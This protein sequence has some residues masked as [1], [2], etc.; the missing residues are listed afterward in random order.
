MKIVV[1]FSLAGLACN[2]FYLLYKQVLAGA[3]QNQKQ[4]VMHLFVMSLVQTIMFMAGYYFARSLAPMIPM[5]AI[6]LSMALFFFT[7]LKMTASLRK[8][9][10][11]QWAFDTSK[12]SV[13]LL[14]SLNS[15]FDALF[16]GIACGFYDHYSILWFAGFFIMSMV[17][18][19]MTYPMGKRT[20]ATTSMWLIAALGASLIGINAIIILV[21]WMVLKF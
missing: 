15:A 1:F 7:G 16:T 19:A 21:E 17:L 4:S 13:L 8:N 10:N 9:K 14:F 18:S 20:T 6:W 2:M 11:Q 5:S 12:L 3:V